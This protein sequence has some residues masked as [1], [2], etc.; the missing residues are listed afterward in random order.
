M[1]GNDVAKENGATAGI[2]GP[3]SARTFIERSVAKLS[4]GLAG[5]DVMLTYSGGIASTVCAS[6]LHRAQG[7][8]LSSVLVNSAFHLRTMQAR[9][10][11]FTARCSVRV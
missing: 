10:R 1:I 3:N 11:G 5:K 6:L 9:S 7:V 2:M 4:S 8:R